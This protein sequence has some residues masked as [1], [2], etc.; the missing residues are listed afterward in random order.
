MDT[1]TVI[2]E[3]RGS[4]ASFRLY[5]NRVVVARL[6][7][8]LNLDADVGRRHI[9]EMQQFVGDGDYI[10]VVDTRGVAYATPD[11]R[12]AVRDSIS[13]HRRAT[14]MIV[15]SRVLEYVVRQYLEEAEYPVENATFDTEAAALEWAH[16]RAGSLL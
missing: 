9:G 13:P 1:P 15:D 14:G 4:H 5:S 2:A 8:G 11:G 3:Q 10:A 12:Q 16:E 7:D 6:D